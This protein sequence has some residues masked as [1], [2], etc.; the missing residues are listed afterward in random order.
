[1]GKDSVAI[2]K[3][4]RPWQDL[5]DEEKKEVEQAVAEME[6]KSLQKLKEK[7]Y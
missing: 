3:F 7:V 6:E 4:G 5:T 1:M 2:E